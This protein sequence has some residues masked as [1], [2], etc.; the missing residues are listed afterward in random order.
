MA[1]IRTET[2]ID[3]SA[4][5]V[6]DALRDWGAVHTRLAPGF[7]V[8]VRL[9]D[10]DRIV[11]FGSGAVLRER[12]VHRDEEA[13]RL[14]WTIVDDPYTHHNGVAQVFDEGDG[15]SRF[16]WTTDLLPDSIEAPTRAAMEQGTAVIKATLES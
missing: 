15:R 2:T 6:W 4:E 1:S 10:G 9:D 3:A 12:L 11:T 13:R 7:V 8:D 5:A 14:V 16:V